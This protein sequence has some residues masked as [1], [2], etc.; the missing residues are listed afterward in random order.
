MIEFKLSPKEI[1]EIEEMDREDV[2]E[3]E[4]M[5]FDDN[6]HHTHVRV[7]LSHLAGMP[8]PY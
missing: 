8:Y 6:D 7:W 1:E 2:R 5:W 3:L 4:E